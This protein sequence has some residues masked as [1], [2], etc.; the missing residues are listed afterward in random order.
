MWLLGVRVYFIPEYLSV[1]LSSA[2][3]APQAEGGAS[4]IICF[5]VLCRRVGLVSAIYEMGCILFN[6][7]MLAQAAGRMMRPMLSAAL[8][9][10]RDDWQA[11]QQAALEEGQRLMRAEAEGHSAKQQAEIDALRVEMAAALAA[12]EEQLLALSERSGLDI[13]TRDQEHAKALAEQAEAAHE[14]RVQ[15]LMQAAARRMMQAGLTKGWQ[16][17]RLPPPCRNH[18]PRQLWAMR[19][20]G[21]F[22]ATALLLL[23]Q[24]DT[25]RAGCANTDGN[26]VSSE[27]YEP[28]VRMMT[29]GWSCSTC[30]G[31]TGFCWTSFCGLYDDNDF[32]SNTMCCTCGG[33]ARPPPLPPPPPPPPPPRPPPPPP[34]PPPP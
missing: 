33:G 9:A 3:A 20:G 17:I 8:T 4:T 15:H 31:Q 22:L 14:T 26:A 18:S 21:S 6:M 5:A 28:S 23:V 2:T 10:W 13:L 7:R 32:S 27:V 30:T 19:V 16:I 29:A 25:V 1:A 11:E 34:P 12:K 24:L